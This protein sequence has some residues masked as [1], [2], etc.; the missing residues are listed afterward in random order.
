MHFNVWKFAEILETSRNI[1]SHAPSTPE[2]TPLAVRSTAAD[3]RKRER[4]RERERE[5]RRRSVVEQSTAHRVSRHRRRFLNDAAECAS[6]QPPQPRTASR[7]RRAT[8]V[9]LGTTHQHTA[10]D[11]T[12]TRRGC[13]S[14]WGSTADHRNVTTSSDV[15]SAH[16]EIATHA[17]RISSPSTLISDPDDPEWQN[18]DHISVKVEGCHLWY[19]IWWPLSSVIFD[20]SCGQTYRQTHRQTDRHAEKTHDSIT[21]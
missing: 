20:L 4:E 6:A 17:Y 14:K 11:P 13:V 1:G 19:Q 8:G 12:H 9:A 3:Q 10:S 5:R 2:H 16:V 7:G 21:L 18:H 15:T